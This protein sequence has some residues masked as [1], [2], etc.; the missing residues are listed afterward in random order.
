MGKGCC[1]QAGEIEAVRF[2]GA[3]HSKGIL[4]IS[5]IDD[6]AALIC[7]H[8]RGEGSRVIR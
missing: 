7:Q 1:G 2:V 4:H 3:T 5:K 6:I 8:M